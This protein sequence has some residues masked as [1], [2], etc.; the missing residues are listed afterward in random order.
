MCKGTTSL[1]KTSRQA[2]VAG[3]IMSLLIVLA[4]TLMALLAAG[5]L[6]WLLGITGANVIG[7]VLG[8][9]PAA[10]A[11]QYILG[12]IAEVFGTAPRFD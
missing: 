11:T 1:C 7:R 9:V 3:V 10:L 2:E 12:G 5:R 6:A 8:V 4:L